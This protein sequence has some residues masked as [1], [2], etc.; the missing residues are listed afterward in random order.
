LGTSSKPLC[1]SP[2][3]S[4]GCLFRPNRGGMKQKFPG[5]EQVSRRARQSACGWGHGPPAPWRRS[6]RLFGGGEPAPLPLAFIQFQARPAPMGRRPS[7]LSRHDPGFL[8]SLPPSMSAPSDGAARPDDIP[9][10]IVPAAEVPS[11][12][13]RI[14]T[15]SPHR[16]S[17][18]AARS[19]AELDRQGW[20]GVPPG[21]PQQ[22]PAAA[23]D[24][25]SCLFRLWAGGLDGS[26]LHAPALNERA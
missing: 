18:M 6:A 25:G 12:L 22:P 3:R 5:H 21:L 24:E 20:T 23:R 1:P 17:T 15:A 2:D 4:S 26:V 10:F 19:S 8:S 11:T 9:G 13:G 16:C 7:L 14:H